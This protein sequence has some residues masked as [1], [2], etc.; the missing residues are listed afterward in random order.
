M[1]M[2]NGV[3]VWEGAGNSTQIVGTGGDDRG[4]DQGSVD[5][6]DGYGENG[7]EMDDDNILQTTE[8]QED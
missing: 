6:D 4:C 5:G 1:V 2:M 3:W 7:L 8:Q